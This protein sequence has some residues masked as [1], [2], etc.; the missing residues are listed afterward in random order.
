MVHT[1]NMMWHDPP[2]CTCG[3]KCSAQWCPELHHGSSVQGGAVPQ[4]ACNPPGEQ[5]CDVPGMGMASAQEAAQAGTQALV[6]VGCQL[7]ATSTDRLCIRNS[8]VH[9]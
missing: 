5:S 9:F 6:G 1:S 4:H 2:V 7:P 3:G 8:N